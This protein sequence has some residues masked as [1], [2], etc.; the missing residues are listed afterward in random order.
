V[1]Q[2]GKLPKLDQHFPKC[3]GQRRGTTCRPKRDSVTVA[4]SI[5]HTLTVINDLLDA[6]WFNPR[7][8][9]CCNQCLQIDEY[10]FVM[11][12]IEHS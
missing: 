9:V 7:V 4:L 11:R 2:R 8:A 3:G 5:S 10:H 6:A 1:A 12:F